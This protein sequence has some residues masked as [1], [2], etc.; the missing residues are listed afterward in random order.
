MRR[1]AALGL[2]AACGSVAATAH[3]AQA[4]PQTAGLPAGLIDQ[5]AHKL[6][7]QHNIPGLSIG[8]VRDGKT[9]LYHYGVASK[10][11]RQP[12]TDAT[13][14]EIGSISKT[15]TATLAA[16][17]Q[18]QGKLKLSDPV[19]KHEPALQGSAFDRISLINLG[20]HTAGGLPLQVPDSVG[21]NTQLLRYYQQWQPAYEA[22]THRVYS[23]PSIGLLGVIAGKALQQPFKQ[24]VA[25]HIF[26]QL[27]MN[28]SYYDVPSAK[29]GDY[30]Q[31]YTRKGQPIRV[32]PGVLDAEAYGVKTNAADMLKF[33]QANIQSSLK[34]DALQRAVAA[35]HT[36]YYRF[37][38]MVQDLIWEQYAYPVTLAQLK[39]GNADT[40]ALDPHKAVVLTPPAAPRQD[41]L[42]NKTGSTNGFAAYAAF[43]PARH[44]GIVILANKNYPIVDRIT[45]ADLILSRLVQQ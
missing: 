18:E 9:A 10:A 25:Q 2:L 5:A 45:L 28:N 16:Y 11:T 29:A 34:G 19:S 33:I 8:I 35:T 17:A 12:V 15:F 21:D 42:I 31:G 30:A 4:G 27:A 43:I 37:G 36:G 44:T 14:F 40:M 39:Q 1:L 23:N 3:A 41:V 20:T 7:R 32:S 13:L 38:D 24:A 26:T 6:M 22:G